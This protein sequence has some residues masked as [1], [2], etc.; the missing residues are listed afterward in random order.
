MAQAGTDIVSPED[1]SGEFLLCAL[2]AF[3]S[4]GFDQA[5][6]FDDGRAVIDPRGDLPQKFGSNAIREAAGLATGGV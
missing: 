1:D 3:C 6:D 4:L 2:R 5:G